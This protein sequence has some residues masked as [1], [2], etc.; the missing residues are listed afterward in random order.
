VVMMHSELQQAKAY[1][2]SLQAEV[3]L[4]NEALQSPEGRFASIILSKDEA[5]QALLFDIQ[6][7]EQLLLSKD[8][9]IICMD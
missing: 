9:V 5:Y 7:K 8:A 4:K 1:V 3:M 6:I 2:A